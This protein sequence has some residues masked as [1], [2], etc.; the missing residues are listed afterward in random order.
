MEFQRGQPLQRLSFSGGM[1]LF[2]PTEKMIPDALFSRFIPA[3]LRKRACAD[4]PVSRGEAHGRLPAASRWPGGKP[5]TAKPARSSRSARRFPTGK[6]RCCPADSSSGRSGAAAEIQSP[7]GRDGGGRAGSAST[8][9]APHTG[10]LR[11]CQPAN[12][13]SGSENGLR[14]PVSD[15]APQ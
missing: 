7:S 15:A 9:T 14:S 11:R 10:R 6:A 13:S 4:T 8:A 2:C 3:L 1:L 5:A 12:R